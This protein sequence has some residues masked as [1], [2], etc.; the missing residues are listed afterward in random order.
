MQAIGKIAVRSGEPFRVQ[1]YSMLASTRH[2]SRGSS[3]N[4]SSGGDVA[5]RVAKGPGAAA[6]GAGVGHVSDP[7]GVAASVGPALDVLDQMYSS[8]MWRVLT[9]L[10]P[11]F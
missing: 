8:K 5:G 10:W 1:C 4:S 11:G 6:A 3:S 9:R 2:G 7:L